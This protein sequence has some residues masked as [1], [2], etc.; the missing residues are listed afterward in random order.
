MEG[1]IVIF[2]DKNKRELM[3]SDSYYRP[4][5][6]YSIPTIVKESCEIARMK[7]RVAPNIAYIRI[8]VGRV[9]NPS[10]KT[11]FIDVRRKR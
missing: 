2:F 3:G 6:R 8:G 9:S 11:G 4:D 10:F 7:K 1:K 5:G